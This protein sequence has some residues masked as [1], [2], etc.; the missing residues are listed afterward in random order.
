[1]TVLRQMLENYEITTV[2]GAVNG[3]REVMQEVALAG[4]Y[5]GGFF[6]KVAFYGGPC[7]RIFLRVTQVFRKPGFFLACFRLRLFT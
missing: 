6:D 2:E 1:M 4:L 5:R 7:L 3:L